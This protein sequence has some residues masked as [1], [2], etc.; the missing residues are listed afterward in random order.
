M[1]TALVLTVLCLLALPEITGRPVVKDA[2]ESL[3]IALHVEHDG[4]YSENPRPPY[5]PT[6]L[7]EPVPIM[8]TVAEI[9]AMD[10]VLGR[11]E[12]AAY[13]SGDRAR[14][15]K[16]QNLLWLGLL[17]AAAAG[18]AAFFGLSVPWQIAA[19]IAVELP[20]T[21]L[22]PPGTRYAIGL[23]SLATELA[24]AAL[25]CT[26]SLVLTIG[27]ARRRVRTLAL[28]S[29]VFGL[30][31]LTK[32]A[33]FYIYPLVLAS[34]A[35]LYA[36]V[37]PAARWIRKQ[38]ALAL[39]ALAL[40][41]L[42]LCSAWMVRNHAQTGYFQMAERGGPI[43]LYR[44]L[45]D[46]MTH[47][48]YAGSFYAWAASGTL[49]RVFGILTGFTPPDLEAGGRLQHLAMG[50]PGAAGQ[51]DLEN[52]D[53][54]RPELALTWYRQSRAVYERYRRAE[55]AAG[56]RYPP[57]AAD[58]KTEADGFK[59]IAG[60]RWMHFALFVPLLLRGA[61]V[62]FPLLVLTLVYARAARRGELAVFI[63]PALGFVLFYAM[64]T[65]F[66]QRY[67]WLPRPASTI[68]L[69]VIVAELWRHGWPR[70]AAERASAQPG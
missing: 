41:F 52:E 35:V 8:V 28:A 29:F 17:M 5:G 64:I 38:T 33:F 12:P 44:G 31:A 55:I 3:R 53:E 63:L 57:G 21:V 54:G 69:I 25:L 70:T 42:V 40:P 32:A 68:A 47:E 22:V 66:V 59:L 48:E 37:T 39:L 60:R 49:Q 27:F 15:V 6:M 9:W 46:G 30:L 14:Y 10:A 13:F 1:I 16:L 43:V 65:H 24:G 58:R 50:L 67:G 34:T 45:L 2:G 4:V 18:S 61:T 36:A 23:D 19:A 11:A 62:I 56:A 7:R 51:R 20:F 26:G